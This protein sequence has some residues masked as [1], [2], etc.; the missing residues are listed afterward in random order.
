MPNGFVG[1]KVI[2]RKFYVDADGKNAL[3]P[4]GVNFF[5]TTNSDFTFS[6]LICN[7]A[8]G[9]CTFAVLLTGT[10]LKTSST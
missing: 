3:T 6:Y 7:A 4:I 10:I 8:N 5:S 2:L 9:S 1:R